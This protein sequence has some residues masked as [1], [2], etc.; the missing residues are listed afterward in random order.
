MKVWLTENAVNQEVS[1]TQNTMEL[2]GTLMRYLLGATVRILLV[3]LGQ[4]ISKGKKRQLEVWN[5]NE[6]FFFMFACVGTLV[7]NVTTDF[8]YNANRKSAVEVWKHGS[9]IQRSTV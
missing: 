9:I 2:I 4:A 8:E 3:E 1:G 7:S 5:I 6:I